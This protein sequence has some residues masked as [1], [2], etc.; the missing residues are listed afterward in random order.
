MNLKHLTTASIVCAALFLQSCANL[1][2][3]AFAHAVKSGSHR[4]TMRL[5]QPHSGKLQI[6]EVNGQWYNPLQY[7]IA[8]GDKDA[9]FALI[10][11][12]APTQFDGK[13]LAYNAARVNHLDLARSFA[14]AGYG[15]QGDI[16]QAYSD[17]RAERESN[18]RA[19]AAALAIGCVFIAA[20]LSSASGGGS[21][22]NGRENDGAAASMIQK[23]YDAAAAGQAQPYPGM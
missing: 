4:E 5:M 23:N 19:N 20:L 14:S 10:E 12:G 17:A 9:S 3:D 8:S 16:S 11:R 2:D 1:S 21:G 18:N 13:S 15:S 22:S 7:S 6:Q